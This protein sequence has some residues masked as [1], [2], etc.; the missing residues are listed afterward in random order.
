MEKIIDIRSDTVTKPSPGMREAIADAEVGDDV[1]EGDPT[2]QKLE[3]VV[4]EL[5]AKEAALYVPSGTMGNQVCLKAQSSPGDEIILD[6]ESHIANYEVGAAAVVSGLQMR[7]IDC[8]GGLMSPERVAQVIRV[9]NIHCPKSRIICLENTH[10]RHGGVVM[11]LERMR[12]IAEVARANDLLVHLDGARIWNASA[13]TG[14]PL[15]D[16]AATADS[17]QCCLSKGLGAPI[18]SMVVGSRQFIKRARR[19]R[20]M[21]GGGMRQVG[22]LAAAGLYALEYNL[23][24]V[25]EDHQKAL[26]F[27]ERVRRIDGVVLRPDPPPTNIVVIDLAGAGKTPGD[28]LAALEQAG[29]WMVPFGATLIRAVAHLDVSKDEMLDAAEVLARVIEA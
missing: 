3:A 2:V 27:A 13:A 16:Y 22:I 4:A 11:P 8:P 1:F 19:A 5:F 26:A 23:P 6:T 12:A 28:V 7:M 18:G 15:A 25:G 10:N 9:D 24:R 14:I 20:K 21:F 29:V 17:L